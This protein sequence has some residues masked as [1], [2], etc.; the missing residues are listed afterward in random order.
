[1]ILGPPMRFLQG[2][3]FV[4]RK[5]PYLCGKIVRHKH[6]IAMHNTSSRYI[7][8]N[9]RLI[10][11][12]TPLVMG[13]LNLTPDSF[14]AASRMQTDDSIALRVR[15]IVDEGGGIIDVG[16]YSSRPGAADVSPSEEMSRLRRGLSI[17]RRVCP[18][19]VLSVDTFRADVAR[20]CV[21]EFGVDIVNDISA[22]A[23]DAD[24]FATVAR[25]GVPYVLMHMQGTPQTMQ[26]A[27]TYVDPVCDVL[28]F[29]ATKLQQ[30]RE[31]GVCD[32]I[33]DPG[34]GF[35]KT[36]EDNY[37]LLAC[38]DDFR[39]LDAPL[40]VGVSRKSMI[41]K[42]LGCTPE[43]SLNGTTVLHTLSLCHGADIL[44]VHDVR[45]AVEAV[46]IVSLY[47]GVSPEGAAV[48]LHN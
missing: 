39:R 23:L 22:G 41:Y 7:N 1:M 31:A 29:L 38:L 17:V 6:L 46:K 4:F 36:L 11:L 20:M 35:G 25:L 37:R 28:Q 47:R 40:L 14:Y 3:P 44:R 33:V 32:I 34:F 9:G 24:M 12:S 18:E 2:T 10:D 19:A 13:I 27:P 30:L 21:E 26:A 48:T 5:I 16:A 15:Q 42:L 45:P 43:D 8:A